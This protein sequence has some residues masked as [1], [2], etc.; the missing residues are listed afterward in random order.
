MA[1]GL[2]VDLYELTMAHSYL[3]RGMNETATFAY[4]V[5]APVPNRRF[6]LFSGLD[7]LL[8]ALQNFTFSA[9]DLA[10]LDSLG[11]FDEKFLDFLE[12][13]RFSGEIWA[14][15]EGEICF[16]GEPLLLVT[17]PRIQAQLVETLILNILNY[18]TLVASKAARVLLAAGPEAVVVDFSPRR[19]HGRDAALHAARA[20]F[21]AGFHGTSNVLAGKLYG[22]P[23]VGTMA[24]SYVLSFPDEISA[25]R[26][27]VEDHP[28][29]ILLI[30]T[31]DTLAGAKNAVL[32]AKEAQKKGKRVVG[33]RLDSGNLVS[34]SREVRR[35]LDEAGFSEIKIFVSGDLDEYRILEFRQQG[36]VAWGYGVGTRLGVSWDLPALGGVYKLVEDEKGP[37]MK[38]S[39]GK[40]TLPGKC[41]VWREGLSDL[42]TLD[43][44]EGPGRPLLKKVFSQGERL[45]PKPDLAKIRE[46][47]RK[48]LFSLPEELSDLAPCET[49]T[50][51]VRLSPSLEA[52]VEVGR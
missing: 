51:P 8:E 14:M 12:K 39:P 20:S 16:P 2:F 30:D 18:E 6:L 35:I 43:E 28:N 40:L 45:W 31:Y 17:A 34:L 33:V 19:D 21:L 48:T 5:R 4:F 11:L 13:F 44:E 42:V 1:G 52:L 38:K 15:E 24:H 23:V 50:Y 10:Y 26:A 49:P 3:R 27:F 32:V 36:G 37:R 22:I 41:Q 9:E 47:V 46:K 29:P 25:F 7:P